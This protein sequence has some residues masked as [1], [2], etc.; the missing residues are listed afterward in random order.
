ML[1]I[2]HSIFSNPFVLIGLAIAFIF[3]TML[4][5]ESKRYKQAVASLGVT[6]LIF[7]G[8]FEDF[9]PFVTTHPW[10]TAGFVLAY[11]IIGF[12]FARHKWFSQ[13]QTVQA[14]FLDMKTSFIAEFNLIPDF[15]KEL[16]PATLA[17]LGMD[18]ESYAKTVA[19]FVARLASEFPAVSVG[20]TLETA[21]SKIK[22][23][24]AAA[25]ADFLAWIVFWPTSATW[26]A[27]GGSVVTEASKI[28]A[29]LSSHLQA[30]SD[31]LFNHVL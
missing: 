16:S 1:Q 15:F 31:E 20:D 18:A 19:T 22:P 6:I 29:S 25:K 24:F 2:I 11:L 10:Q 17:T 23:D 3:L 7:F 12:F 4:E 21:I 9:G 27:I 13:A 26:Y 28:R 14:A 8:I 30:A 5:T